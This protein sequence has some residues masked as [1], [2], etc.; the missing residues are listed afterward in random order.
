MPPPLFSFSHPGIAPCVSYLFIRPLAA[1][2]SVSQQSIRL[3]G[4]SRAEISAPRLS[5]R[6]APFLSL[7]LFRVPLRAIAKCDAPLRVA[8]LPVIKIFLR[9]PPAGRRSAHI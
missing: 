5:F 7:S 4:R 6:R 9:L 3:V 2:E 1:K 8:R